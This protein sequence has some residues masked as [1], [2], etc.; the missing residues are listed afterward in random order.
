MAPQIVKDLEALM[1]FPREGI[2][3]TVLVKTPVAN[4]TLM[5]MA[6]GTDISEHT[7]TREAAV[8]VLKGTGTFVLD[9]T[10]LPMRPGTLIFM[11]R[12][13]PHS[14]RADEDL[15]FTLSLFGKEGD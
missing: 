14:L 8:T 7:S 12:N 2:F 5:C 10:P 4:V 11:P 13:A 9:G 6:K 3:S 15:A 1:A